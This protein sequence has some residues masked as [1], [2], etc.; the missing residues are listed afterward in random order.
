MSSIDAYTL[1]APTLRDVVGA[2]FS[3]QTYRNLAYLALAFPLGLAY[4]IP[5]VVGLSL[6]V[7]LAVMVVGVPLILGV[8]AVSLGVA[9][10]ERWLTVL[11]LGIHIP[12]ESPSAI[13]PDANLDIVDRLRHLVASQTTWKA[14]IYLASKLA[15]GVVS[16][17]AIVS[18]LTTAVTFLFTP[19]FYNQPGVSVGFFVEQPRTIHPVVAVGWNRLLIE[20]RPVIEFATWEVSTLAGALLVSLLGVVL[21]VL[22]FNLLNALAWVSGRYAY[23]MLGRPE[24]A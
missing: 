4:F 1:P 19:L 7:G 24:T 23:F 11:L 9:S 20:I 16:F 6:G 3:P 13:S 17:T 14:V 2:P 18:L 12:A 8:L 5:L 22:A 15:F 21:V 10:F